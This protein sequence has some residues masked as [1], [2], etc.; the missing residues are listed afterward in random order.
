MTHPGWAGR[1][2]LGTIAAALLAGAMVPAGQVHGAPQAGPDPGTPAFYSTRVLPI[3]QANCFRCHSGLNHRGGLQMDTQ[4]TFL[5]GGKRGAVIVP[6]HPESS[7]LVALI[8]HQGPA[9]DPMPMPPK[10][11]L[12]DADI[13]TIEQWI[14]AGAVMPSGPAM[15]R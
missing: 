11:K 8:K 9:D 1:F 15:D 10:S 3:L 5:R 4:A 2:V 13:A 12:A 7:L 14:R 6:G